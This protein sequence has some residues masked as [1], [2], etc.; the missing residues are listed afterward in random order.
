MQKYLETFFLS[1]KKQ[2]LTNDLLGR[3]PMPFKNV[4]FTSSQRP[5]AART[6]SASVLPG[7]EIHFNVI[8]ISM[9][10]TIPAFSGQLGKKVTDL[11]VRRTDCFENREMSY[12]A[13]NCGVAKK[14]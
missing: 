7:Y 11:I 2:I 3:Y 14:R 4:L 10:E 13:A 6:W 9:L 12:P 5:D 1:T 8:E